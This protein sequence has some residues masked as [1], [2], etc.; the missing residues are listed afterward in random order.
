MATDELV[1]KVCSGVVG[2]AV[3]PVTE[4]ILARIPRAPEG[5]VRGEGVVASRGR[6]RRGCGIKAVVGEVDRGAQHVN[7]LIFHLSCL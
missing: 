3:T 6:V 4:V 2:D 1:R 5:E 7:A